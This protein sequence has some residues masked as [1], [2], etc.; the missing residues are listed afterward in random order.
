MPPETDGADRGMRIALIVAMAHG[1]VIGQGGGLPWHLPADLKHFK[2]V[3]MGKPIIMGRATH[4][5]IG[6]ALPGRQN[7]VL[8]RQPS[9]AAPG[10]TV[11]ST[12]EA[13]LEAATADAPDE[14]MVI[15]GAAVYEAFLPMARR[16]Y[17]TE[18]DGDLPGDTFFPEI[19]FTQWKESTRDVFPADETNPH[20]YAFIRYER[21]GP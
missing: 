6:R 5:S 17:L 18:I 8:T 10:C 3:T 19:D 4:E 14:V 13:A 21:E 20:A 7:I 12:P 15:G 11:V 9:Y 16:L 1:R 2:S